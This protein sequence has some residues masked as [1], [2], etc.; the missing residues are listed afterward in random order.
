[1]NRSQYGI[2][3]GI[4]HGDASSVCC[5]VGKATG[6]GGSLVPIV[7]C[8]VLGIVCWTQVSAGN[9]NRGDLE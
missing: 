8:C 3:L 1:M 4:R 6:I 9:L 7:G 5:T 2:F